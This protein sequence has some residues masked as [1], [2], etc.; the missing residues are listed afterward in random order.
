MNAAIKAKKLEQAIKT[1]FGEAGFHFLF[2]HLVHIDFPIGLMVI[3]TESNSE[4]AE[5]EVLRLMR[6]VDAL[7]LMLDTQ[8]EVTIYAEDMTHTA[9]EES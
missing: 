2:L 8:V 1:F 3:K 5:K 7:S 4:A 6:F 9:G